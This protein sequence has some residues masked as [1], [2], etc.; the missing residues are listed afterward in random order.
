MTDEELRLAAIALQPIVQIARRQAMTYCNAP[1]CDKRVA[2]CEVRK[3]ASGALVG[4]Y[5]CDEHKPAPSHT[6][7]AETV[8]IT[9]VEAGQAEG[10]Q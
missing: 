5:Y 7:T 8:S 1:G 2:W 9:A 6:D 4:Y 3:L 10:T